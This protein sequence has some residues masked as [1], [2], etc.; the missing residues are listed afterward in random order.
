MEE[1]YSYYFDLDTSPSGDDVFVLIIYDIEENKKRV[2]LSKYLE[3]YG[4]RVQKSAFEAVIPRAK[5]QKM[6]KELPAYINKGDND[7]IRIYKI[8]GKGQV[9]ILGVDEDH[10]VDDV[11]VI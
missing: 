9:T 6:L 7:S 2:K 5:Y 4:F 10:S 1:D 8:I 11:I 3:G